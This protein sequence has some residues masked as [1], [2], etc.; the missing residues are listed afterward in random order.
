METQ[1]QYIAIATGCFGRRHDYG[2]LPKKGFL[3]V[4]ISKVSSIWDSD[5]IAK[6]LK[7]YDL[8]GAYWINNLCVVLDELTADGLIARIESKLDDGTHITP[9]RVLFNYRLSN[10][11][12]ARMQDTGL[13]PL[14]G[15]VMA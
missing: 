4:E 11:G 1:L 3:L 9:G 13:L 7:E 12:R 15:G 6:A 5:L 2:C 14:D 10:F 8:S